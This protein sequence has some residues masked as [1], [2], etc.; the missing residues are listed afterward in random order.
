MGLKRNLLGPVKEEDWGLFLLNFQAANNLKKTRFSL[1]PRWVRVR[2]S[3]TAVNEGG[4]ESD[5]VASR[6]CAQEKGGMK[7]DGKH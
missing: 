6:Q 5:G 1:H 3:R 4:L 7:T 2:A